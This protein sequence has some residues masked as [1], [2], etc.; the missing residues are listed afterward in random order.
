MNALNAEGDPPAALR[1]FGSSESLAEALAQR[2][3]SEL[4]ARLMD[5]P[6]A[7]LA[8]SG[9]TTPIC[10]F[11]ALSAQTI[12]WRAVDVVPVDER[13]VDEHS[14]RSNARLIRAHLLRNAAAA[15]RFV[16]LASAHRTPEEGMAQ[17]AARLDALALPPDVA[18]L[19]MGEDG[20][21][22]SF[23]PHGE[24]LAAALDPHTD[25]KAAIVRAASVPEPRVTLTFPV[26]CNAGL[27]LLHI[28]GE[29]KMRALRAAENQ[30]PIE[31]MPIRAFLRGGRPPETFWRV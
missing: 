3:A 17:I 28:E 24:G 13:W 18:I 8:V 2:V 25:R 9:G 31:D 4:A 27:V 23:F 22:A 14:P 16:S 29:A 5:K 11:E 12:D 15:A 1:T 30:G 21:T 6:R 7:I 26:L 19:G 20:H 10:F